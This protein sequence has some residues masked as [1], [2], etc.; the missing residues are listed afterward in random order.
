MGQ[1]PEPKRYWSALE[2]VR[3]GIR[4]PFLGTSD[5]AKESLGTLL[6]TTV[7]QQMLADVPLGAF[8][9]GGVDSTAIVALMQ[10]QSSRPVKTFTVGFTDR[11]Y[12]EAPHAREVAERLGTDHTELYLTP[13]QVMDVIPSLPDRYDEPF[14]DSSQIPTVLISALARQHVTVS[15]SG[16]GGDE[17]FGGYNRYLSGFNVWRG[18]RRLPAFARESLGRGLIS[19]PPGWLN[20]AFAMGRQIAPASLGIREPADK[21]GKL[22]EV[23]MIESDAPERFYRSLVSEWPYPEQLVRGGREPRTALSDRDLWGAFDDVRQT[24]MYLDTISYLPDDILT[25]VDRAS[26]SVSLEARAPYLDHRIVEFA[27]RLP[28]ELKFANGQ[29]K[30]ILRQLVNDLLPRDLMER[31]KTGFAIPLGAWLRGPLRDW[32]E[33]LLDEH[34]IRQ[35]GFLDPEPITQAWRQHLTGARNRQHQ[36]W[37]VL[38]FQAWLERN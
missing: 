36:L 30:W 2:T 27:W 4:E 26:M 20:R 10:E 13:Q 8:L 25:K 5:E 21:I 16:D 6:R 32:A 38:M 17:V 14:A 18:T 19:V 37:T 28:M 15:L 29:G 7:R 12:D 23:L 11:D 9:S 35:Q 33:S 31:P 22:A 3:D 1:E 24:M 34:K